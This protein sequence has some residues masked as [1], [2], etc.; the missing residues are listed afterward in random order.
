LENQIAAKGVTTNGVTS[1]ILDKQPIYGMESK[2]KDVTPFFLNGGADGI[3]THYLCRARAALSQLS[4]GPMVQGYSI[5]L[6]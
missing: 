2:I 4:Y 3:R 6:A 1:L 5:K